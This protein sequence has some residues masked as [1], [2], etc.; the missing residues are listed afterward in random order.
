M[1]YSYEYVLSLGV[2]DTLLIKTLERVPTLHNLVCMYVYMY[3]GIMYVGDALFV[4]VHSC[5][6]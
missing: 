5:W 4:K 6:Q 2:Y 1:L 3:V